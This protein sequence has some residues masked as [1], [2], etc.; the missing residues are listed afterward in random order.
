MK[1]INIDP[2]HRVN[3]NPLDSNCPGMMSWIEAPWPAGAPTVPVL[4]ASTMA[5]TSHGSPSV[6]VLP[7]DE[8]CVGSL[9]GSRADGPNASS[10]DV[11]STSLTSAV[12]PFSPT[13]VWVDVSDDLHPFSMH[14]L[15]AGPMQLVT[16]A[17]AFNYRVALLRDGSSRLCRF[18]VPVRRRDG[19]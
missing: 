9:S 7:P 8:G 10:M 1:A 19:F 5:R 3:P 15:D 17:H 11:S 4:G 18:D 12:V 14:K 13:V 6:A 16:I 2:P